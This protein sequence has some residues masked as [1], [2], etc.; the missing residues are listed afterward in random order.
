MLWAPLTG[1][2]LKNEGV[3]FAKN[4]ERLRH[5]VFRPT[6]NQ[7]AIQIE[8]LVARRRIQCVGMAENMVT[9]LK[10]LAV[11]SYVVEFMRV[12]RD[13]VLKPQAA[14][15]FNVDEAFRFALNNTIDLK[16]C[17]QRI[18][19]AIVAAERGGH[20][21]PRHTPCCAS[22]S[23]AF[24]RRRLPSSAPTNIP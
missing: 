16:A 2:E 24:S 19:Q 13:E 10:K 20:S 1:M 3:I 9:D 11:P 21:K 12:H 7:R 15:W 8:E 17:L 23:I 4:G 22:F 6:C 5:I 14:S 18:A